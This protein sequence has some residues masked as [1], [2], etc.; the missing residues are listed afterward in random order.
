MKVYRGLKEEY[1]DDFKRNSKNSFYYIKSRSS[2]K[3][4]AEEEIFEYHDLD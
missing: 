1:L 3:K 4:K 2:L